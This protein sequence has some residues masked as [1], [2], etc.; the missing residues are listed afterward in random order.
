M[1]KPFDGLSP[2]ALELNQQPRYDRTVL[3]CCVDVDTEVTLERYEKLG[4]HR[5]CQGIA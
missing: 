3:R 1:E 4:S 2:T 5:A